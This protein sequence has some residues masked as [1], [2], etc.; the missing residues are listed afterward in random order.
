MTDSPDKNNAKLAAHRKEIRAI[1]ER[2]FRL[3][4]ER[5]TLA[6]EIGRLKSL[7]NLPVKD[8]RVEKE[9]LKTNSALARELGVY[10]DLAHDLTQT[11]I[12][13]SVLT[14]D[15]ERHARR[16]KII[17]AN[18]QTVLIVGGLG[19]MGQ[20]LAQFFE[21]VGYQILIYD[22]VKK[23]G[24]KKNA[25]ATAF[26][27]AEDFDIGVKKASI[28]AL[29]SPISKTAKILS[30]LRRLQTKAL[31]FDI[32]SLKSPILSEIR[33][34]E[35]AGM[36]ITS[37]H[38][39]FGPNVQTL[40]GR[41]IV[42]CRGKNEA[43]ADRAARLFDETSAQVIHLKLKEH[44]RY[45]AYVLGLSHFCNL[46]FA[47]S[48]S[49]SGLPL[50]DL[51]RLSSTTFQRQMVVSEVV[52]KEN[53]D[54]YFEIQ[55]ENDFSEKILADFIGTAKKYKTAILKSERQ[56]FKKYMG[57]SAEYFNKESAT[58]ETSR[59]IDKL[60]LQQAKDE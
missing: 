16:R 14:Q 4:G 33:K 12:K 37:I 34:C 3:V 7:V 38:P 15:E 31:I 27:L 46:V 56:M 49:Q 43:A 28:I 54:L 24:R 1:D 40:S 29:A 51:A 53:P 23:D 60:S 25:P 18:M 10:E 47:K 11:L 52:V 32:C 42:I 50:A 9:V 19:Q 30:Q 44:D 45:I 36:Q 20:W 2:L 17:G 5:L 59:K 26:E 13:Y 21:T 55:A 57:A 39:M 58:A 6:K 41:N 22:P 48:L 8:Y 35:A